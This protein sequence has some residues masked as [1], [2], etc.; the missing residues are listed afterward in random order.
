[1]NDKLLLIPSKAFN[2]Y[3]PLEWKRASKFYR[4]R[5]IPLSG[6]CALNFIAKTNLTVYGFLWTEEFDKK[7]FT[8]QFKFSV[9]GGDDS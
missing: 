4:G 3:Y 7:D 6:I 1:M 9:D 8:L 2:R 5:R